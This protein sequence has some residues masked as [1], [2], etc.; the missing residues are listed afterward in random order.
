MTGIFIDRFFNRMTFEDLAVKYV[1]DSRGTSWNHY[2]DAVNRI[3]TILELLEKEKGVRLKLDF[4][5]GKKL[6]P[7]EIRKMLIRIND[8]LRCGEIRLFDATTQEIE[9]SRKRLE[10]HRERVRRIDRKKR[11]KA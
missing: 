4:V 5:G 11:K 3:H 8:G 6:Q 1:L 2:R 9:A 10:N 7:S